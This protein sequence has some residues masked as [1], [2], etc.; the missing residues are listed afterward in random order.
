MFA[1]IH[2]KISILR[3][4]IISNQLVRTLLAVRTK[5]PP[6][7]F[8][9]VSLTPGEKFWVLLQYFSGVYSAFCHRWQ[10]IALG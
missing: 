3:W 10:D 2:A 7:T 9:S 1:N 5:L 4:S 8:W 6:T